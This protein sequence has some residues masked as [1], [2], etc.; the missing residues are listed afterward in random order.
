MGEREY[1]DGAP[2]PTGP[3]PEPLDADEAAVRSAWAD[4]ERAQLVADL[5]EPDTF[6]LATDIYSRDR[7][8]GFEEWNANQSTGSRYVECAQ[9]G[10]ALK[11]TLFPQPQRGDSATCVYCLELEERPKL[12]KPSPEALLRLVKQTGYQPTIRAPYRSE[13]TEAQTWTMLESPLDRD[14]AV[15]FVS[16]TYALVVAKAGPSASLRT[17]EANKLTDSPI[18]LSE[19][20]SAVLDA[21]GFTE[22]VRAGVVQDIDVPLATANQRWNFLTLQRPG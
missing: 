21:M 9:C 6:D 12:K 14:G 16:G 15:L 20:S 18:P 4:M 13:A 1:T 22:V 5:H 10:E 7:V 17:T 19:L 11:D 2:D 8:E 3:E